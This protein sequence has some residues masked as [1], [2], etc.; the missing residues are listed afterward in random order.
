MFVGCFVWVATTYGERHFLYAY[1]CVSFHFT[2]NT[3]KGIVPPAGIDPGV[4]IYA[5]YRSFSAAR[6]S[7]ILPESYLLAEQSPGSSQYHAQY[8]RADSFI[9]KEKPS[10]VK[11]IFSLF[12]E[13]SQKILGVFHRSKMLCFARFP[14]Q[15]IVPRSAKKPQ[16]PTLP[17]ALTQILQVRPTAAPVAPSSPSRPTFPAPESRPLGGVFARQ[18]AAGN[19]P[20]FFFVLSKKNAPRPVEEKNACTATLGGAPAVRQVPADIC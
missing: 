10:N 16:K 4:A 20:P 19:A 5:T 13:I 3:G 17:T 8:F 7:D 6:L 14:P 12:Y 18:F 2:K 11:R 15:N 1:P 9:I